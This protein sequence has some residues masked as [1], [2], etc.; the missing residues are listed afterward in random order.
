MSFRIHLSAPDVGDLEAKYVLDA[1]RSGWVAPHGPAIDAFEED[2][3]AFVGAEHAVALSSGTAALHLALLA[4]GVGAG[5]EVVV[6]TLTFAATAFAVTYVGARPVFVDSEATSWN[7]DP[8]LLADFLA[9]RAALGRL[10]AAVIVVDIFGQTADYDR[11][12]PLCDEYGVTVIEDAA[13]AL[14]AT[15]GM[16]MAG[17]FGRCGVFSFNGNKIMTTSGGGMLVTD[18]AELA[19]RVRYLATQARQPVPWYEH[20]DIGFNYRMSNILAALGRA[21][22]ERLPDLVARRR[23]IRGAYAARLGAATGLAVRQDADWGRSNAWL[24]VAELMDPGQVDCM[25]HGLAQI[26][27]EARR[28]WKPMH[29]QPVFQESEAILNGVA[30]QGYL[31]SLCLPSGPSMSNHDIGEVCDVLI[32]TAGA[33]RLSAEP[34]GRT[35]V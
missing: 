20:E 4:C 16:R 1:L 9:E 17:T 23:E 33:G 8:E 13:E 22:L 27:V 32:G 18:D 28:A 7:L 21:Q 10:P 14:G 26:R 11:I 25:I 2:T 29:L 6:P 12:I 5:D 15:H 19:A 35:S 24:T 34:K 30:E 3:K 31:R